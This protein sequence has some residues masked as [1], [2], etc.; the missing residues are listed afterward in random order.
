MIYI[1][2][3]KTN[4]FIY[5]CTIKRSIIIIIYI[6]SKNFKLFY[7]CRICSI[8]NT[9]TYNSE[10]FSSRISN[11]FYSTSANNSIV[12]PISITT[13]STSSTWI[14]SS[15]IISIT[16]STCFYNTRRI[17]TSP[18]IVCYVSIL[19]TSKI[20]YCFSSVCT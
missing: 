9:I 17:F 12:T 5:C 2:I 19:C 20:L 8:C 3:N 16:S 14:I 18:S 10:C 15:N 6:F 1:V 11:T 4:R 13:M 7:I